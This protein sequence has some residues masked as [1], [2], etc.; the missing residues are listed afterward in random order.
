MSGGMAQI[1][2]H[3][4]STCETLSSNSSIAKKKKKP[5]SKDTLGLEV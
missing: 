4:P 1:V 2:Y 3:L 5:K